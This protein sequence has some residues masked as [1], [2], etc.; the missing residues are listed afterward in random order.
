MGEQKIKAERLGE[1][2]GGRSP[3][4]NGND[5]LHSDWKE[6]LAGKAGAY[7]SWFGQDT[8]KV[9]MYIV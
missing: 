6:F 1:P 5:R 9:C 4:R 7:R 3:A 8:K 2:P